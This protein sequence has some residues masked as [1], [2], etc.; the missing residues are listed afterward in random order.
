M[1]ALLWCNV[2][3]RPKPNQTT[4]RSTPV[5]DWTRGAQNPK[6]TAAERKRA[7]RP[8]SSVSDPALHGRPRS[9]EPGLE[10]C[11]IW[12]WTLGCFARGNCGCCR[13]WDYASWLTGH[14]QLID[15]GPRRISLLDAPHKS[16]CLPNQLPAARP[17]RWMDFRAGASERPWLPRAEEQ[18]G[19]PLHHVAELAGGR[20][21]GLPA[22][23]R[24][25]RG[26]PVAANP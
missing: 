22:D 24:D 25:R 7:P 5:T 1:V 23:C 12:S 19:R 6:S 21:P 11:R 3:L 26:R 14:W 18:P 16:C 9:F 4:G 10:I 2:L 17:G 15:S 13:K 8:V 20:S